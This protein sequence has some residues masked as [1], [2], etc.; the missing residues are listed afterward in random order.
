MTYRTF[1]SLWIGSVA[2][3]LAAIGGNAQSV[4]PV[5]GTFHQANTTGGQAAKK[6]QPLHEPTT[7]IPS[8]YTCTYS[9][10]TGSG[11]TYMNFCITV[12]GTFANFQSPAGVEM[13]NQGGVPVEGYGICDTSTGIGY[14]DYNYTDSGN[15]N[16][17]ITL[18][19][20]TSEVKIER[21]TSDS[22]WTLTQTITKEAG[23]PPYAKVVMALKNN[24]SLTKS[25]LFLRFANFR[26]DQGGSN[27]WYE[28]Y[29]GT[30]NS[31]WG[32]SSYSDQAGN[33]SD[34][35]GLMLQ[36]VGAPTPSST[37]PYWYGFA[38]NSV[39]GPNP[40]NP[41]AS[42]GGTITY[43]FGSGVLLYTFELAKEKTVTITDKYFSF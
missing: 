23:P 41:N 42:Y 39:V 2:L 33:G 22:L 11:A 34:V 32:Y 9:F 43:S 14:Y 16:A 28:N 7:G 8:T 25:P 18:T 6:T 19:S 36:N 40:C 21:T 5:P 20:T 30:S 27:N 24:S 29:D 37:F 13:L 26:P 1:A 31:T 10:T 35:Y 12:N 4:M 15:W 38:Q 17:P 3:M